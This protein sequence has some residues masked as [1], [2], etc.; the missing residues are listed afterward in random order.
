MKRI[1]TAALFIFMA[2][3]LGGCSIFYTAYDNVLSDNLTRGTLTDNIYT[4]AY[5]GLTF[6]A[7]DGW[8]YATD[9]ELATLMD[10]SADAM[11]DAGVEFSEEALEKQVLYDMQAK[12]RATGASVLLMYENLAL[13]GNTVISATTYLEQIIKQLTDADIYQYTFG[14]ITEAELCGKSY[15]V[16]Q[17]EMTDYGV[18]QYYYARKIDKYMLYIFVSI[19][20]SVDAAAIMGGFTAYEADPA[21]ASPSV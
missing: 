1:V 4:S 14:E 18:T 17:A 3:L 19:P 11:S 6:T 12:D 21:D 20:T 9:E 15:Q 10:L 2:G 16:V 13:T 8:A 5:A 7:P